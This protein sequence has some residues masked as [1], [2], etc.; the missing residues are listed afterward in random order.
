MFLCG[1]VIGSVGT[2][3]ADLVDTSQG[4]ADVLTRQGGDIVDAFFASVF[5]LLALMGTGYAI[6][7]GLRLRAEES[8][9]HAELLLSTPV[10]RVRWAAGHLLIAMAGAAVVVAATGLG[11]GIAYALGSHD[12]GQ[13]PRL[14]GAALAD[15]PAVWVLG[16]VVAALF[17][18]LPRATSLAW[19]FLGAC[20]LIW[21]LGPL[22]DVP[23]W[24][25]D[26]SPYQ[27]VPAVP[28][29]TADAG[30]LFALTAVAAALIVAGLLAFRRR[31]VT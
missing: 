16:A 17:G 13:I 19:A 28:A 14:T 12:A 30:P 15:L 9:G 2:N 18:L 31:D 27:H 1:I 3:A 5:V 20:V 8:S 6:S 29:E 4:V 25:L 10:A 26:I 7:S 11:A 21:L 22:L 24:L 23:S